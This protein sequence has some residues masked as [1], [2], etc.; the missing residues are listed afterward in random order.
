MTKVCI[1]GG[2]NLA[3]ATMGMFSLLGDV[4]INLLTNRPERWGNSFELTLPEGEV[5][6]AFAS[7]TVLPRKV[8]THIAK[9]SADPAELVPG[10]DIV[11]L[12]LPAFL[13]EETIVKLAPFV[14]PARLSAGNAPI[15]GSIVANTGF[16]IFCH[17]HLSPQ[18]KLFSFQRVPY[19]ARVTEYAKSA[20]LLGFRDE[21]F[22]AA[23]N[24][25]EQPA[26]SQPSQPFATLDA[27][28][29]EVVRLFGEKVTL[30]D[31]FYEVT[32][33]NSN[34]ILHTGRLYTMLKDWDGK[35]FAECPLFYREWTDEASELDIAMDREFFAL[36]QALKVDTT[37][38]ETLLAHYEAVDAAGMTRKLR[39]IESLSTIL[40][41]MK[42]TPEGWVPDFESRYFTEDFPFGLSFIKELSSARGLAT[43]NID[44]VLAWGLSKIS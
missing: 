14:D 7:G 20:N 38:I 5:P 32:L 16:F 21:L 30:V 19:V 8:T 17:K 2:G 43:P 3:H 42:Q 40:S 36:L 4:S 15:L 44:K 12:C 34:P 6:S 27:F 25:G 1:V 31:T 11:L 35:P 41:P 26:T 37:H 9:V 13:V 33:S 39:S 18:A 24:I 23:E 28:R 22:M 29:E 10:C